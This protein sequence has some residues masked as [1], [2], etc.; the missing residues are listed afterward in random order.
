[1]PTGTKTPM[2]GHAVVDCIGIEDGPAI[3]V[4]LSINA[5]GGFA[6]SVAGRFVCE[7]LAVGVDPEVEGLPRNGIKVAEELNAFTF[8]TKVA[9]EAD[10]ASFCTDLSGHHNSVTGLVDRHGTLP[11][12]R[13]SMPPFFNLLRIVT[14]A[15]GSQDYGFA[16]DGISIAFGIFGNNAD[17]FTV[18]G[19]EVGCRRRNH[20]CDA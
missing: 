5:V 6:E 18:L 2:P 12:F 19:N 16:V 10:R 15:S 7:S 3:M 17:D 9:D 8:C 4:V 1:M 11:A 20:R 13:I 14:E